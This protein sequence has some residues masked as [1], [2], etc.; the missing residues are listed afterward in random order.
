V[1]V[2]SLVANVG[3]VAQLLLMLL[4]HDTTADAVLMLSCC[5]WL[6]GLSLDSAAAHSLLQLPLGCSG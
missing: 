3:G 4:H 6:S 5:W 2:V 1:F